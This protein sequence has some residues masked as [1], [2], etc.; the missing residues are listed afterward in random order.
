MIPYF[1]IPTIKVFSWWSIEPFGL[2]VIAGVIAGAII[3][4]PQGKRWG[5]ERNI[6]ADMAFWALVVAF[7]L[8]HYVA[9]FFYEF[10]R[11]FDDPW[12][13]LRVWDG[14]SSFGGFIGGAVGGIVYLRQKKVSV[15]AY[16]DCMIY[17]LVPGWI[18]GRLACTVVHDHPGVRTDFILAF[19]YPD[20]A[21]HNL[22]FYEF[23]FTIGIFVFFLVMRNRR[24]FEGYFVAL[25]MI[26]YAPV[27]FCFDFLRVRDE[28]YL[29][30]TPGQYFAVAMLIGGIVVY[31][32]AHKAALLRQ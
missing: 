16:G 1:T 10:R 26:A 22:G 27:R 2:L 15:L 32:S 4:F 5:L 9:I 12:V 24:P 23:L 19:A 6:I 7:L 3:A 29:G 31:R 25:V 11:V 18:F 21:R 14:L 8:A 20:G 28:T 17:G 30:F 13:L